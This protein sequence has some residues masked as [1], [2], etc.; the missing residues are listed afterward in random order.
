MNTHVSFW[1]GNYIILSHTWPHLSCC[2]NENTKH[3]PWNFF[4]YKNHSLC[5][6]IYLN[7]CLS[8]VSTLS[9]INI[10]PGLSISSSLVL[11]TFRPT[12]PQIKYRSR[13]GDFAPTHTNSVRGE[14]DALR[15]LVH[16]THLK[17][18]FEPT[19]PTPP[20][21][22]CAPGLPCTL[23]TN[24]SELKPPLQRQSTAGPAGRLA[25][26]PSSLP[27]FLPKSSSFPWE[28]K[29]LRDKGCHHSVLL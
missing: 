12:V 11:K 28:G 7:P 9:S 4:L 2:W 29:S 22:T 8:S 25:H 20:C 27:V 26:G 18:T 24:P 23:Q 1:D 19:P 15:A 3:F 13:N 10:K 5:V 14:T 6:I 21:P 16:I 17:C